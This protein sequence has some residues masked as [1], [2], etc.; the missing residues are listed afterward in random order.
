MT[1]KSFDTVKYFS[2]IKGKLAAKLSTMTLDEQKEF[3]R[4]IRDGE[5]KL[6]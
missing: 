6:D 5:I 3:L 4:K 1:K 2:L